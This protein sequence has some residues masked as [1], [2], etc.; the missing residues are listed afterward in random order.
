[1][2]IAIC[3]DEKNLSE[4]LSDAISDWAAARRI[5]ADILCYGSAE[6]FLMAWPGIPFDLAFIDIQL[7]DMSGIQ[8]AETIRKADCD[9]QIVF[10]TSFAQY[11]LAGYDVGALH[12][13]IKPVTPPKLLPVLDKAALIWQS[14]QRDVLFVSDGD[15]SYKLPTAHIHYI[16]M[17]AHYAEVCTADHKYTIRKTAK[18]LGE[19]LPAHII[20]CHRSYL[21]NLYKV[22]CVY[23]DELILVN[24][25]KLPVSR[26]NAKDVKTAFMQ[27][28]M[29]GG[30]L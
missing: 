3:E 2:R 11:S 9:I 29:G 19:L 18:E 13:L 16:S 20:R 17:L 30:T 21:V 27:L 7:K 14:R 15:G 8:L 5:D 24:D 26:N 23:K 4:K 28:H 10:A 25:T 6:A 1:M 22:D 12:Y